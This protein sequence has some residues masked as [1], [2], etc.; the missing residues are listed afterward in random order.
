MPRK[1]KPGDPFPQGGE[2]A[3]GKQKLKSNNTS[4]PIA[5]Y[6]IRGYLEIGMEMQEI[7]KI[8]SEKFGY[9][10]EYA[11]CLAQ[12]ERKN[13]ED[14]YDSM[15]ENL[16]QTNI[17]RLNSMIYRLTAKGDNKSDKLSLQAIDILNKMIQ[18]YEQ[19]I[20]VESDK[21]IFEIKIDNE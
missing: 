6:E 16:V 18:A 3:D 17:K 12:E 4:R 21:P 1:A 9:S 5:M 19:K 7:A 2:R 8:I 14:Y 13:F 11:R 10:L 15:K 20:K